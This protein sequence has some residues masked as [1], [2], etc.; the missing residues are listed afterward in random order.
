MKHRRNDLTHVLRRSVEIATAIRPFI[1][2]APMT[3]MGKKQS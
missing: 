3:A 1:D 2:V